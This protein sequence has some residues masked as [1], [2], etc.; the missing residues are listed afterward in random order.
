MDGTCAISWAGTVS[1][2][3]SM[4]EGI[5]PRSPSLSIAMYPGLA[6]T[7][8]VG[9]NYRIDFSDDLQT[10]WRPLTNI[11]LL[12]SPYLWIDTTGTNASRRAY[13]AVAVS[14]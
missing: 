5:K 7:G 8:D 14:P 11:T 10:S 12:S 3:A 2:L 1:L 6:I 4:G 13:R 9:L